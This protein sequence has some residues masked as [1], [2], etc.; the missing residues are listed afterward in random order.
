MLYSYIYFFFIA[1]IKSYGHR[2]I[3]EMLTQDYVRF[4]PILSMNPFLTNFITEIIENDDS[5]KDI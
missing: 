1:K 4:K 2:Y 5:N 3:E